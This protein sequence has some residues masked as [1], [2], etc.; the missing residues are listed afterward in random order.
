M[1]KTKKDTSTEERILNAA[2][3]EFVA[4]G[5]AGARMQEIADK[6]GINKALL[7]YY[8]RSKEKLFEKVFIEAMSAFLP[9]I[10][11]IFN[12]ELELLEKVKAFCSEYI[13]KI[14]ENPFI[15]LFVMNE[16]NKQPEEFVKNMWGST[17]PNMK[18]LLLQIE[19]AVEKKQIRPIHPAHLMMNVIGMC[20][21]PFIG[22]PIVQMVMNVSEKQF[23][24]LM[25][26]R[27]TLIPEF[28]WQS[29]KVK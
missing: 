13:D 25:Q 23:A 26:E 16:I 14:T 3:K 19:D 21:F 20:I 15:P 28:V 10:N 12:S 24:Q 27:K 29:I 22:K 9:R 11:A 5:L 4:N 6:A 7:H 17:K 1:V 8:F 18:K 2:R